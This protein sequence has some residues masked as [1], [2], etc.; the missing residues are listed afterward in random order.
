M[1]DQVLEVTT[2]QPSR[3]SILDL[4]ASEARAF[5]LKAESYCSLD[6]PPYIRFGNLTGC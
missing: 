2:R 1:T 6:L 4:T 5:L 3:Q